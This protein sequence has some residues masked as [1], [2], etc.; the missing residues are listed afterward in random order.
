MQRGVVEGAHAELSGHGGVAGGV[1]SGAPAGACIGEECLGVQILSHAQY[2]MVAAELRVHLDNVAVD[3]SQLIGAVGV[4]PH[5]G[6]GVSCGAARC[7]LARGVV[8]RGMVAKRAVA[9]D[10][11]KALLVGADE[12]RLPEGAAPKTG[13]LPKV[14]RKFNLSCR[15]AN[16]RLARAR[17]NRNARI[18][19][20][21]VIELVEVHAVRRELG[22]GQVMQGK[23]KVAP[24]AQE[25][26]QV[27]RHGAG[28]AHALGRGEHALACVERRTLH[29]H[30]AVAL[31]SREVG[32]H[33]IGQAGGLAHAH[34]DGHEQVEFSYELGPCAGVA[35]SHDG[36]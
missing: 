36:I 17:G 13:F 34:V 33:H 4:H 6:V 12:R 2:R 5:G 14:A 20:T 21:S 30:A 8:H 10:E 9:A 3:E 28:G 22:L 29:A 16:L 7:M 11:A 15:H 32:Q 31:Q 1:F 26:C 25:L 18:H 35:V 23:G 27:I 19:P 24:H